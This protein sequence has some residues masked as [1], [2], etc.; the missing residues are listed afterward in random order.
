MEANYFPVLLPSEGEREGHCLASGHC[1]QEKT[2]AE[3]GFRGSLVETQGLGMLG[4]E[5]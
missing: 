1:W 4:M 3:S 5:N 2:T